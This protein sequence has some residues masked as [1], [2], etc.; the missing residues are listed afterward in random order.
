MFLDVFYGSQLDLQSIQGRTFLEASAQRTGTPAQSLADVTRSV[1]VSAEAR[2]EQKPPVQLQA[3]AQLADSNP[4]ATSLTAAIGSTSGGCCATS[5]RSGRS[6]GMG[7]TS[8]SSPH[9]QTAL[10]S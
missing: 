7:D 1:T 8:L 5:S 9:L 3:R 6:V 4:S 2:V 10:L